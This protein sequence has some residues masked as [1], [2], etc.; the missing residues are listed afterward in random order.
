[1][2]DASVLSSAKA[3]TIYQ[4]LRRAP[5][6]GS[7]PVDVKDRAADHHAQ[8]DRTEL[9]R[10][11]WVHTWWTLWLM[12]A[13]TA[14]GLILYLLFLWRSVRKSLKQSNVQ[15]RREPLLVKSSDSASPFAPEVAAAAVSQAARERE[16]DRWKKKAHRRKTASTVEK[17]EFLKK[18]GPIKPDP[19]SPRRLNSAPPFPFMPGMPPPPPPGMM[20]RPGMHY[21]P[22]PPMYYVPMMPMPG[23]PD[24]ERSGG[25]EEPLPPPDVTTR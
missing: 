9:E 1:V 2:D 23:M 22:P 7:V 6:S 18:E 16:P 15:S 10:R 12:G 20:P 13:V 17:V 21:G 4:Q 11:K 24:P 5:A 14:T 8:T 3:N 25:P 19:M